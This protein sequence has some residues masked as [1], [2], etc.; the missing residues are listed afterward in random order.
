MYHFPSFKHPNIWHLPVNYEISSMNNVY[1]SVSFNFNGHTWSA[2]NRKFHFRVVMPPPVISTFMP[3]T[4]KNERSAA[5]DQ[6]R[7]GEEPLFAMLAKCESS[8]TSGCCA[9]SA[10]VYVGS[11]NSLATV[12]ATPRVY[13]IGQDLMH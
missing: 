3:P 2:L 6:K 1:S 9:S 12:M 11:R 4:T 7:L 13:P 5:T 8:E 10:N